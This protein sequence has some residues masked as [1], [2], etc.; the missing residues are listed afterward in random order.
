[1]MDFSALDAYLDGLSGMGVPAC[2]CA[3]WR[4]HKPVHRHMAGCSDASGAVPMNGREVYWLFSATKV[5]TCVA[6]MQLIMDG[7][8]SLE[9][10]VRAYL[11]AYGMLTV[12]SGDITR[13]A[14]RPMTIRHIMSMQGGMDYDLNAKAIL[15]A[16]ET[17]GKNATTRELVDA[18]AH[19]PLSFDPGEN[20]QYSLCHD[21]LAAVIEVVSGQTF[22]QYLKE[23]IFDPLELKTAGFTLTPERRARLTAE[24][25][26]D[27]GAAREIPIET[28]Q[29]R[30]SD[31]YESGGAGLLCDV[32]DYIVFAD[33]LACGGVGRNGARI[34][35]QEGIDLLRTPQLTGK[36][37]DSF[38]AWNRRG[39]TYALGVRVL[40]EKEVSGARS[41]LGEFGWDGAAGAF[42]LIDP[43]NKV[44]LF[45]AQHVRSCGPAYAV[46][47]PTVR[48][49]AYRCM[50]L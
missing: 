38:H 47:H 9:D 35:S 34:L 22:G 8:L 11:P 48:D 50:G 18:M 28:N 27:N 29:Y 44:S 49:L 7:R 45:Y 43:A 23:H 1:M 12:A 31:K 36:A 25:M 41:A 26:Y 16:K 20:F 13:A 10:E 39:Y 21:V 4:D 37:F 33:A 30:L 2:D 24:Y 5:F 42:A 40:V 14:K 3:L 15:N 19:K 32:D 6:A 17:Y 46:I